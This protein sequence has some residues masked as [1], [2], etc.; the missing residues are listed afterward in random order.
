MQDILSSVTSL[1]RP[2]LLISAARYALTDYRRGPHL[3]RCLG[4]GPL[5]RSG[6]AL[7]CLL[8]LESLINAQRKRHDAAYSAARHVEVLTA[9]MGEARLLRASQME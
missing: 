7:I 6:P 8:E 4:I 5:P 9:I 1:R 2:G 3:R